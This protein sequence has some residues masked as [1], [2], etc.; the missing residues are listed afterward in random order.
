M[1]YISALFV[2]FG[3]LMITGCSVIGVRTVEEANYTILETK[4]DV[5]IRSYKSMIIA[6]TFVDTKNYDEM[7]SQAFRRLF[8]YISGQNKSAIDE[9]SEKIAMTAPVYMNSSNGKWRMAF[10][11]PSN[12]DIKNIPKPS[13]DEV[14]IRE[15]SFPKAAV[16]T[17]SGSL[18]SKNIEE[19]KSK[20]QSWITR[21]GYSMLSEPI[22]AGYDPPWTIPNLR[23]N[24]ILI[25][26]K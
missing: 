16:L 18:N 21:N 2:V 24:E 10:V 14:Q 23:R 5:Q 25:P 7:S 3:T 20:L 1:N 6:E 26:I 11:M 22:I 12:Y 15:I 9:G 13:S 19:K 8:N 4:G 17:F